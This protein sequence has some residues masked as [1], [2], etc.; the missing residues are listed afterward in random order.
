[1]CSQIKNVISINATFTGVG[2]GSYICYNNFKHLQLSR[3]A[4]YNLG[5]I[6]FKMS[7]SKLAKPL[8]SRDWQFAYICCLLTFLF[9]FRLY[10]YHMAL[11]LSNQLILH[12]SF[13]HQDIK[14]L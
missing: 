3:D 5:Y 9:M 13:S 4:I 1:M 10:L 7:P 11:C 6:S 12:W 14:S 8:D 2:N